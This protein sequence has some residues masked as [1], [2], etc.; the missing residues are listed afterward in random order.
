MLNGS[1]ADLI[2]WN[3]GINNAVPFIPIVSYTYT[4][5]GT[6]TATGCTNTDQLLIIVNPLPAV[7]GGVDQTVCAGT[8]VALFGT[9]ADTYIWTNNVIDNLPFVATNSLLCLVMGTDTITGCSNVDQVIL[10]VNQLPAVNAG[11]DQSI[12]VG[13]S[14]VLSGSGANTYLWT[15]NITD[16][17]VFTPANTANYTLTGTD[18]NGC[19]N[20]DQVLITV[21]AIPT[22]D[23]GPNQ[24]ICKGESVILSGTGA[25]IYSWD[26]NVINGQSFAPSNT[27]MYTVIGTD[28]N[29]CQDD[30]VVTVTVNQ[31]SNSAMN[32]QA[33]NSFILNGQTYNQSGTYYQTLTNS[34]G[35]DSTITLNLSLDFTGINTLGKTEKLIVFPN[36]IQ[37][38][39]TIKGLES[40]GKIESITIKDINGKSVKILDDKNSIFT[41]AELSS[42]VYFLEV[43][44]ERYIGVEKII[45]E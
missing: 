1:G 11:A 23:A 32:V 22:V 29:G 7:N 25:L 42:G 30:D 8:T 4:L 5:T 14:T 33:L 15:N 27:Q 18:S 17:L 28:S 26:N 6:D 9:G 13:N 36:P 39:F 2:S 19:V 44:S 38:Q 43:N 20:T 35:C 3:S 37:N 24:T 16:G 31:T 21:N 45:K 40:L 41:I 10:T 12:C 34:A